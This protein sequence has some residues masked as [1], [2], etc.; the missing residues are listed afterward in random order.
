VVEQVGLPVQ[1]TG[2]SVGS[3]DG[4]VAAGD[5]LGMLRLPAHPHRLERHE[6][7][8]TLHEGG[9]RR[10]LLDGGPDLAAPFLTDDLVDHI[11][12]YTA[13]RPGTHAHYD[14]SPT[15]DDISSSPIRA[16]SVVDT[17]AHG[18]PSEIVQTYSPLL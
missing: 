7:L 15:Y 1:I 18:L 2:V 17:S 8:T 16:S 11:V 6:L 14:S 3:A 12:A 4:R 13:H 9:V 5:G 10:L